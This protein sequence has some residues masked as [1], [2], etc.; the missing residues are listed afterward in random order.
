LKYLTS[1]RF[2]SNNIESLEPCTNLTALKYLSGNKNKIVSLKG[3]Q[4][5]K[6]LKNLSLCN[7]FIIKIKT[8][9]PTFKN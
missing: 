1:F 9:F 8:K 2:D 5:L 4:N 7:F 3:L 6:D